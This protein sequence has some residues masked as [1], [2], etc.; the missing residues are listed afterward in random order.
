MEQQSV[1]V[2]VGGWLSWSGLLRLG[3]HFSIPLP[4]VR[5]ESRVVCFV[6]GFSA[7][8]LKG[9]LLSCSDLLLS[10]FFFPP[11]HP[12][13]AAPVYCVPFLLWGCRCH[14]RGAFFSLVAEPVI[15]HLNDIL[16]NVN[17]LLLGELVEFHQGRTKWEMFGSFMFQFNFW[18]LPN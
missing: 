16:I 7:C 10:F 14:N 9:C 13:P 2:C 3:C 1:C 15:F 5:V 6:L 17:I 11:P 18:H 12:L 4:I 8:L